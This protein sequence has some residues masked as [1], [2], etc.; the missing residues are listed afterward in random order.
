MKQKLY[1]QHLP[2]PMLSTT[3]D[4][5][6]ISHSFSSY[7]HLELFAHLIFSLSLSPSLS[8]SLSLFLSLSLSTL[9]FDPDLLFVVLHRSLISPSLSLSLHITGL[10]LNSHSSCCHLALFACLTLSLSLSLYIT[11]FISHSFMSYSHLAL[12]ALLTC[13]LSHY[14]TVFSQMVIQRP[15]TL[16]CSFVSSS[17]SFFFI[18]GFIQTPYS[19]F[20]HCSLI[21]CL[22]FALS[23]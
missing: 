4:T 13:S 10:I 23:L 20:P 21:A 12:F 14:V 17:L 8:L 22:T 11:G 7:S 6:F 18:T 1:I 16:H 15:F 19:S 3:F 2:V 9:H 5:G